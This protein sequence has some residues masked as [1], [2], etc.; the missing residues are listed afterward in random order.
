M[1]LRHAWG[2]AKFTNGFS[3]VG[4]QMWSLT[5]ENAKGVSI[6]DDLGRTNDA[7][8][9]TIDPNYSVGF[10][11]ARQF[12]FRVAKTFGDKVAIAFAVENPQATLTSH[13]NAGNYLLGENG[14]SN[15]YNS[16]ATYAFNPSPDLIA[17]IAFDPGFGHYEVFGIF[18]RFRDRVFPCAE[19]SAT[20][21]CGGAP[22]VPTAADAYNSA[23]N[24]G[25]I[26]AS[27]RW[28]FDRLVFGLK[29]FGGSGVG[30]YGPAG[31]SDVSINA[32]GTVHIIKN[33]MGL[34]TLELQ[35]TKK[36]A[37]YAYG[38][39]EYAAR[40]DSWDPKAAKG[41][42]ALVGYGA[43]TFVNTG[44]YSETVPATSTGNPTGGFDPG[45]LANCTA[46]SRAV[47]EGTAGFWYRVYDGNRGRVQ[48]GTQYSYVTRQTW[49]GIGFAGANQPGVTPSGI[50]NMIFTS[51]RY[52]LP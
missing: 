42:G 2:Q 9:K 40:T 44:C 51:F 30:R 16:T 33:L 22:G 36:L 19:V 18:D 29:G 39:V 5:T 50:D 35:A 17:K 7:R 25:G 43:P 6:D 37:F 13:G 27:A 14:A 11:F 3:V 52:Y 45:S 41:A 12:G 34:S 28:K 47:I 4:G 48:F 1:R 20:E 21:T 49:S 26:G 10:V 31:L 38:G 23:K 24:G 15:S 32:D 46:D 8:P